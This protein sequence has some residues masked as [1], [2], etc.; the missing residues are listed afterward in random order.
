MGSVLASLRSAVIV[1]GRD[2][3]VQAWN[4]K[5][6]DM[7]GLRSDEVLGQHLG[8]LDIGLP[9]DQVV[10]AVRRA[11][12]GD[13]S[14]DDQPAM[15]LDALNRRWRRMSVRVTYGLLASSHGTAGVILTMDEWDRR[16]N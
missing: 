5:A 11:L 14:G 13:M 10:P 6:E 9:V 1:V 2:V 16:A 12:G 7:W 3:E 8:N 4:R 15:M